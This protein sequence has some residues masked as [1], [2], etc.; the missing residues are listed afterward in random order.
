[1]KAFEPITQKQLEKGVTIVTE[2]GDV[3][4]ISGTKQN[5]V[6]WVN[7]NGIN[8]RGCRGLQVLNNYLEHL[9]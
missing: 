8:G 6:A 4:E 2:N 7:I 3:I 5:G 9:L 1:M